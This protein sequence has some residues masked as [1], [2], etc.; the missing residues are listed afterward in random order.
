MTNNV[1][2]EE[3]EA[4]RELSETEERTGAPASVEQRDF[5]RP[6][7]F[8]GSALDGFRHRLTNSLPELDQ[9]LRSLFKVPLRTEVEDLTEVS[10]EGLFDDL[11]DPFALAGFNVGG[12]PA[13]IRWDVRAA[14][15]HIESLLGSDGE[16]EPRKLSSIENGLLTQV[17]A[18]VIDIVARS[19]DVE[20]SDLGV[21]TVSEDIA[22]WRDSGESAEPHRLCVAIRFEGP[23]DPSTFHLYLPGFEEARATLGEAAAELGAH[24]HRVNVEIGAYL[25]T[26][27]V[28][29]ASL[30]AL[31]IGDVIPL[32]TTLSDP[33]VLKVEGE[34]CGTAEM[35]TRNGNRAV[36][37]LEVN[38]V[39][40]DVA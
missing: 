36:R 14:V 25:G 2:P 32:G 3:A 17:F 30:L 23:G 18:A 37:I 38:P 5:R 22:S 16:P 31:E 7:R 29:L 20:A 40:D 4:L 1:E 10:A 26:S 13:W 11:E 9:A 24:I 33:L 19:L 21:V 35:G 39:L 12:Q 6:R 28:A 15:K 8:S 34:T 27:D